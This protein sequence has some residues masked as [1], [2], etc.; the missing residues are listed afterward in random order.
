MEQPF[1]NTGATTTSKENIRR[2][3]LGGGGGANGRP[4]SRRHQLRFLLRR[5]S[6]SGR[7]GYP[8]DS[9][10]THQSTS[11]RP[12]LKLFIPEVR[13]QPRVLFGWPFVG[14]WN[15]EQP[16]YW[17]RMLVPLLERSSHS[18]AS[19]ANQSVSCQPASHL[20]SFEFEN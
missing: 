1:W 12:S 9:L 17:N 3:L 18:L 16:K 6:G 13:Q 5:P 4:R 10:F 11:P 14:S 15:W 8:L 20:V 2:R 19:I 7:I